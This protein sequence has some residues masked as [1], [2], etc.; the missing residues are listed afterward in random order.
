MRFLLLL[1]GYE[2]FII[3]CV[4]IKQLANVLLQTFYVFPFL[5]KMCV[6]V[7]MWECMCVLSSEVQY[8]VKTFTSTLT[9]ISVLLRYAKSCLHYKFKEFVCRCF[10]TTGVLSWVLIWTATGTTPPPGLTPLSMLLRSYSWNATKTL[11]AVFKVCECTC[12]NHTHTKC[13]YQ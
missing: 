9:S 4:I 12:I 3:H 5:Q 2:N 8:V 7:C 6:C 11:W 1:S 13:S 10:P